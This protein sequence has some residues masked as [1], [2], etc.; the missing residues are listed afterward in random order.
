M[1]G[2]GRM[3]ASL[4]KT[5]PDYIIFISRDTS[6]YGYHYLGQDYGFDIFNFVMERYEPVLKIGSS[7]FMQKSVSMGQPLGM[8]VYRRIDSEK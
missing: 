7:A 1:L 5:P 2:E 6:E 3:L 8:L 4:K